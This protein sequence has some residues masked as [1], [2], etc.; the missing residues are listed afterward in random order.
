MAR[1]AR[2]TFCAKSNSD[3]ATFPPS[4]PQMHPQNAFRH[5]D[6]EIFVLVSMMRDRSAGTASNSMKN[7][8]RV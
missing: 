2:S 7:W 5:A 3:A 4:S 6:L 1:Y 8:M